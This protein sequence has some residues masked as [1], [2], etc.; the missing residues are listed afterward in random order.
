LTG[1]SPFPHAMQ[2]L[3]GFIPVAL[4]ATLF[5]VTEH[6]PAIKLPA[7]FALLVALGH[8]EIKQKFN[9]MRYFW[10]FLFTMSATLLASQVLR[11]NDS[12]FYGLM[13]DTSPD[14][15][16]EDHLLLYIRYIDT[17]KMVAVVELLC[18]M[19]VGNKRAHGLLAA[20]VAVLSALTIDIS[21]LITFGSDGDAAWVGC[22]TGVLKQLTDQYCP[23]L[24]AVHC[25]AHRTA[26]VAKDAANGTAE[27]NLI[28]TLLRDVH[29]F[30][31]HSTKRRGLWKRFARKCGYTRLS[32]DKFADTR[33]LSRLSCLRTLVANLPGLIIFL[34]RHGGE[35]GN[36]MAGADALVSRLK[37]AHTVAVLHMAIDLITPLDVLQRKIQSGNLMPHDAA[38]F[39][40][41]ALKSFDPFRELEPG[42]LK[43]GWKAHQFLQNVVM[44]DNKWKVSLR[45]KTVSIFLSGDIDF[46]SLA[47][48]AGT[49][50]QSCV[51]SLVERFPDR[52][53][54][55]AFRILDP[56]TYS[57]MRAADLPAFGDAEF[58]QLVEHFC[59]TKKSSQLFR[60]PN[61][62]AWGRAKTQFKNVKQL[63]FSYASQHMSFNAV[64]LKLK[65]THSSDLCYVLP[66]VYAMMVVIVNTAEVERGFSIERAIKTRLSNRLLSVTVD[67]L[68][69]VKMLL[70]GD[71]AQRLASFDFQAAGKLYA[72][73]IK[74]TELFRLHMAASGIA[75][76]EFDDSHE[77]FGDYI[78]PSDDD[79]EA[80]DSECYMSTDSESLSEEEEEEGGA[81]DEDSPNLW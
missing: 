1:A 65:A 34:E 49:F 50:S 75:M 66:L 28:D 22:N 6:I 63:L 77:D 56:A 36:D 35:Q 47:D 42:T 81:T 61:R 31:E 72:S 5:L 16:G 51:D 64:W 62:E 30:F 70:P 27:L 44:I 8:S 29:S 15:T 55:R 52:H 23:F 33:W 54:L 38:I 76:P 14:N 68:M 80:T 3:M 13:A 17:A 74:N 24:L 60:I 79:P 41:A 18:N 58:K 11:I 53:L 46:T 2:A 43:S 69:R 59:D 12:P 78:L 57:G 25:A 73:G 20:V 26:L 48:F 9:H 67:S 71:M 45:A 7:L 21:K 37:V 40:D 19:K 39:V 10:S 32:F 4:A